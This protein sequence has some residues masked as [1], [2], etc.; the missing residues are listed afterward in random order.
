[1]KRL[2]KCC[3]CSLRTGALVIGSLSLVLVALAV[4]GYGTIQGIEVPK[5]MTDNAR[6]SATWRYNHE[7]LTEVD[8]RARM[9]LM[10]T[11]EVGIEVAIWIVIAYC[12]VKLIFACLLLAGISKNKHKLM[13][14]W[15]IASGMEFVLNCKL[16][17]AYP[18]FC[19]V[20]VQTSN[21]IYSL[22]TFIPWSVLCFY[23]IRVVHSEYKNIKE[24]KTSQ[25]KVELVK[26][27]SSSLPYKIMI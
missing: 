5:R 17:I 21:G 24:A 6:R 7:Y 13:M 11:V 26:D 3:C 23:A 9:R 15:L 8:Y 25:D 12:A 16:A 18:I 20:M 19:F 27:N 14:P 4:A 10:D 22:L 2:T 1:M